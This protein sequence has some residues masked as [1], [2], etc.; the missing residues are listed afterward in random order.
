MGSEVLRGSEVDTE[1]AAAELGD[2]RLT[3]RLRLVARRAVEAP[4][5]GFPQMVES[6]AELEGFYR[7]LS[8]KR[9]TVEG[10]LAH[11]SARG[12]P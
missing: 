8:N 10:I 11:A 1:V 4:D 9:V 7:F 5:V 2:K 6:D 3:D 12:S